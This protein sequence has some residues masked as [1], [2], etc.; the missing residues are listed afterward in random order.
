MIAG[1]FVG[2][3]A[4]RMGGRP[5]GLLPS[6]DGS[7][8]LAAR[9]VRICEAAGMRPV[10]VG[11]SPETE[12]LLPG[13]ERIADRPGG[14]G[15]IGGFA[16]LLAAAGAGGAVTLACDMP[17]VDEALLR[18]LLAAAP[19]A[20]LLAPRDEAGRWQPFFA[21]WEAA[22]ALPWI[23]AAIERGERSMQ[24]LFDRHA[25]ALTLDAAAWR[26]LRDWDTPADVAAG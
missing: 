3:A 8:A 25:T 21:R 1:L 6:P 10:L 4:L 24:R 7:G 9:L 16:G 20:P 14:I 11:R 23:E 13:L 26:S 12:R 18:R 2:G 17:A 5:K 15:P 19:E 22:R